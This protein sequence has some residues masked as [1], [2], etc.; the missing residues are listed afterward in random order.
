MC[1]FATEE[2]MR[3]E[4]LESMQQG[5]YE[6][7]T[8]RDIAGTDPP[9]ST[10]DIGVVGTVRQM[11]DA[12]IEAIVAEGHASGFVAQMRNVAEFVGERQRDAVDLENLEVTPLTD[13]EVSKSRLVKQRKE[14]TPSQCASSEEAIKQTDF[15]AQDIKALAS[16]Y[17]DLLM[18]P[19]GQPIAMF[20]EDDEAVAIFLRQ[21]ITPVAKSRGFLVLQFHL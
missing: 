3:Q 11:S 17:I 12:E 4:L 20:Y 15:D 9:R 7:I 16:S 13:E 18:T 5:H 8:E 6:E 14:V 10:R 19:S 21:G 2:Q 1:G